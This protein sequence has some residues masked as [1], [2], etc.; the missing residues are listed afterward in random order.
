MQ[1]KIFKFSIRLAISNPT[2]AD[3]LGSICLIFGACTAALRGFWGLS[4]II[5]V[6]EPRNGFVLDKIGTHPGE[7]HLPGPLTPVKF[8]WLPR[9]VCSMT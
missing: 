5:L 4:I 7:M 1:K 6:V 8:S 9:R 2:H 3:W